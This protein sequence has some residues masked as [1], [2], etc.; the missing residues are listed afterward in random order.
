MVR[1]RTR[2]PNRRIPVQV[3]HCG[4]V[5]VSRAPC[6]QHIVNATKQRDPSVLMPRG[7]NCHVWDGASA[8]CRC[9]TTWRM[10]QITRDPLAFRGCLP[11]RKCSTFTTFSVT[12]LVLDLVSYPCRIIR[13]EGRICTRFIKSHISVEANIGSYPS[14]MG[15]VRACE[16]PMTKR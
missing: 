11:R 3:I 8:V 6:R 4:K 5:V 1:L 7:T 10:H 14:E 13:Y 9:R 15:R 2:S 16:D 12:A